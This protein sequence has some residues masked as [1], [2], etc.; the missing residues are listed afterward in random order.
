M[1]CTIWRSSDTERVRVSESEGTLLLYVFAFATAVAGLLQMP[2]WTALIGGTAIALVN[3][4]E[5]TR[6]RTRFAAV[7]ATDVLTTA[8]LACLATGW[9]GGTAAWALGRFSYWAYWS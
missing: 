9:I 3:I 5:E 1:A 8:H 4:A 2:L 7:G 6:L